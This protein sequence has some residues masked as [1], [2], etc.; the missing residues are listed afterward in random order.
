MFGEH[1]SATR[2]RIGKRKCLEKFYCKICL[3]EWYKTSENNL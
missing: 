2:F 3:E 1:A